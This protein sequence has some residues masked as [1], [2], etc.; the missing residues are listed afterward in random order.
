MSAYTKPTEILPIY[1]SA[2]FYSDSTPLTYNDA[3]KE[4]LKLTGGIETGLV[5]FNGGLSTSSI[6]NAGSTFTVP[7]SSGQ[8]AI[9]SQLV[10]VSVVSYGADPTGAAYSDTAFTN[11][12]NASNIVEIPVGNYSFANGLTIPAGKELR[13]VSMIPTNGPSGVILTFANTVSVCVSVY[14]K[15]TNAAVTRL[16]TPSSTSIGIKYLGANNG[17]LE[18]LYAYNHGRGFYF[19]GSQV[20]TMCTKLFTGAIYDAHVVIDTQPEIRFSQCRF[21]TNGSGDV[22]CNAY[23]RFT[24]G[25]TTATA[26]GPNTI[27]FVNSQFNQG[28]NSVTYLWDFS[29]FVAGIVSDTTNFAMIGCHV[30]DVATV[31]HTDGSAV[32]GRLFFNCT[33][34]Y[35]TGAFFSVPAGYALYELHITG[36]EFE[37]LQLSTTANLPNWHI[38]STTFLGTGPHSLVIGTG[39]TVTLDGVTFG[40]AISFGGPVRAN[41][42]LT[43]SGSITNASLSAVASVEAIFSF[44]PAFSFSTG[45]ATFTYTT[46]TG[47]YSLR[48]GYVYLDI[49]LVASVS[50][51]GT[52]L[53]QISGLP[54]ATLNAVNPNGVFSVSYYNGFSN[55][56]GSLYV[57][58]QNSILQVQFGGSGVSQNITNSQVP[59]GATITILITGSYR[60]S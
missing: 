59:T 26:E 53:F 2:S 25:S 38:S 47:S 51:T 36:S 41:N 16:G 21:G 23:V 39:S 20:S 17:E 22:T 45:G 4:F 60:V 48:N 8:L 44:T 3:S 5:T 7:S 6:S 28:V 57:G 31:I 46:Q 19:N 40:G 49:A 32:I 43:T 14:G 58:A 13:G 42:I 27:F 56:T 34:V 55:L 24:G 35:N 54:F 50:G 33:S 30:E 11:A 18:N 9:V 52:G 37:N 10:S 1:N 12:M 29:G 15:F